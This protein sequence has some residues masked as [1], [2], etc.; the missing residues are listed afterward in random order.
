MANIEQ[1]QLE[2]KVD[3]AE[4]FGKVG[5]LFCFLVWTFLLVCCFV[6]SLFVDFLACLMLFDSCFAGFLAFLKFWGSERLWGSFT[7]FFC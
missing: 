6:G 1:G 4:D 2:E 7:W 5:E 3:E